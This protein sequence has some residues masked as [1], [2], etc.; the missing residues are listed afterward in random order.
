MTN[1]RLNSPWPQP[2]QGLH[3][4]E[5]VGMPAIGIMDGRAI[6]PLGMGLE[7]IEGILTGLS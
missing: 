2:S 3:V 5:G 6:I 1:C 4:R 7:I